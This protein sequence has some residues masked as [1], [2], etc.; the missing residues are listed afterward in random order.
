MASYEER[1]TTWLE[2]NPT[3]GLDAIVDDALAE[4][5]QLGPSYAE[6]VKTLRN[7]VYEALD[8]LQDALAE[9]DSDLQE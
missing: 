6:D 3:A 9:A 4:L 8:S 2:T 1:F 7:Q 5:R